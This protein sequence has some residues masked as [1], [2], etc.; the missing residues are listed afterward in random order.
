M[1]RLATPRVTGR[2][3]Q[4]GSSELVELPDKKVA[5]PLVPELVVALWVTAASN[6]RDIL[7]CD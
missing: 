1:T 3:G 7:E 2:P 5:A 4:V 6:V